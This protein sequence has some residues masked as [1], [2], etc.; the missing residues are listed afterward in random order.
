MALYH[1]NAAYLW[2]LPPYL[3][4]S[5]CKNEQLHFISV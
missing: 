2:C 5:Q 4:E 3:I 1:R